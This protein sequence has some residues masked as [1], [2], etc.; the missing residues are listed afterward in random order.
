MPDKELSVD[1]LN[2]LKQVILSAGLIR[3]FDGRYGW[4]DLRNPMTT[5]IDQTIRLLQQRDAP[6]ENGDE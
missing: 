5:V 2:R 6:P 1:D 3:G 4:I